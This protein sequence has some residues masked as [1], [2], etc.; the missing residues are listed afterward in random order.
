MFATPRHEES[1]AK[2][3]Q[4][5]FTPLGVS[6]AHHGNALPLAVNLFLQARL[7]EWLDQPAVDGA[8]RT[9][10]MLARALDVSA[11]H[12][13]NLTKNGRGGGAS[14][15]AAVAELLGMTVDELR[16][17]AK[18][19]FGHVGLP[20]ITV[21]KDD[22]Y[23]NRARAVEFMRDQVLPETIAR[24]LSE[25]HRSHTDLPAKAWADLIAAEDVRVRWELD[26]P[27]ELAAA[28]ERDDEELR[29]M[30]ERMVPPIAKQL[31]PEAEAKKKARKR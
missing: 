30:E 28:E 13:T 6:K 2:R 9:K 26:H 12:V 3:N 25:A 20:E 29:A 19:E 1:L 18:A 10:A 27:A 17:R 7:N 15:E 22:R 16:R 11:A 23:P 24:I 14:I 8:K 31:A 4:R 21:V 5:G